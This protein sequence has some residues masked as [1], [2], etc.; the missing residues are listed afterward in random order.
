MFSR[1]AQE[2]NCVTS[3]IVLKSMSVSALFIISEGLVLLTVSFC[4]TVKLSTSRMN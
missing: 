4:K 2:T 1:F 3:S